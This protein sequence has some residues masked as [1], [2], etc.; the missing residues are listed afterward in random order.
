MSISKDNLRSAKKARLKL[1]SDLLNVHTKPGELYQVLEN[2]RVLCYSC[3]HRCRIA[4][5]LAGVC[6]VRFNRDGQL[7]V[8][9]G[10]IAGL[11][12]D[13]IEKKPF[14]HAL[15]GSNALS[16]GMLGCDLHCDYCQNWI[17]SQALRDP[18]ATIRTSE[19]TPEE[20]LKVALR[21]RVTTITSTY[22]EPLITSEWAIAIFKRAKEL[23]FLTSYVSNGNGTPE[24]LD[25]IRPWTD[26][27]KVDLKSFR[28]RNYRDLGGLL[29]NVLDTIKGLKE[30][31][32]WVEIVTL[33]VPD[34]NDSS[35]E[36]Q[37]M[38]Q[39]L[40]SV[41]PFMPWH[42]TAFHNDYRMDDRSNTS[43]KTL[44][45]AAEIGANAGLKYIYAGNAAG[46]VGRW[47]NTYC[48]HCGELLIERF[49]F[50]IKQI[51]LT[52]GRCP[53]CHTAIPG[54][55]QSPKYST[56]QFKPGD[57]QGVVHRIRF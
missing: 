1:L 11:Q 46:R 27:Y 38:A 33:I 24:V 17:T 34:F 9:W 50:H 2:D 21:E 37:D 18:E 29:N 41:D 10:Y 22:N 35:A 53:S 15:P 20:M 36:L 43:A 48:H 49:S 52:Q 7:L 31:G 45:R 5:G 19:I 32:F 40:A 44:L 8:P 28:D 39:F 14:F 16:F 30:R 23:G 56:D 47:E 42:I 55:W 26:L 51:K 3:G 4:N 57:N 54:V 12:C 6:K 13:P 25:Y